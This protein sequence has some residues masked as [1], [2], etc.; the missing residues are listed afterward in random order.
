MYEVHCI[1]CYEIEKK[2]QQEIEL[3]RN[4]SGENSKEEVGCISGKRKRNS[5]NK[6]TDKERREKK[7]K[8]NTLLSMLGKQGGRL[9]KEDPNT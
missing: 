4:C 3:H 5:E 1:T 7:T 9:M 6:E 8:M 2:K